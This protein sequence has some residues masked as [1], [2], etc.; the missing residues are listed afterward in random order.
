MNDVQITSLEAFL[1]VQKS[2]G[3]F[4]QEVLRAI[5]SPQAQPNVTDA[6][7]NFL[8]KWTINRVTPRRGE[9]V[10][11][12]LVEEACK[13]K[14]RITGRNAIAWRAVTMPSAKKEEPRK[15]DQQEQGR[16]QNG[17]FA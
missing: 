2:L 1:T 3:R 17:L 10:E 6:E 12:G 7:I 11:K 4:Q 9:L 13:R 15:E 14:C 5:R 8:L 16:K